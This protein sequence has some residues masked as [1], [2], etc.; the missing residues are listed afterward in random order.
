MSE[1]RWMLTRL[2]DNKPNNNTHII[3][4]NGRTC[5]SQRQKVNALM[6]M[7]KSGSSMNLIKEDRDVKCIPN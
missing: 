7:Y 6:N 1:M 3:T 4:D 2:S 5:V